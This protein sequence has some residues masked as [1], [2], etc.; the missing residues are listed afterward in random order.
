MEERKEKQDGRRCGVTVKAATPPLHRQGEAVCNG[1]WE[2]QYDTLHPKSE[3]ESNCLKSLYKTIG[4]RTSLPLPSL[5]EIISQLIVYFVI[6]DY[7]NYR[8]HRLFHSK[9]G[10]EKIHKVHHEYA[11]PIGFAAPYEHLSVSR[12]RSRPHDYILAVDCLEAD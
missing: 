4:I 8:I 12:N 7:T 3:A 11:A 6:E 5:M 1:K 10:Y 9:W 2:E